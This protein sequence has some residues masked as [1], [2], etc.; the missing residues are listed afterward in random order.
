MDPF[1]SPEEAFNPWTQ[2]D[3][4]DDDDD[5]NGE[6]APNRYHMPSRQ[7]Q[8]WGHISQDYTLDNGSPSS[9]RGDITDPLSF[10]TSAA[11][12]PVRAPSSSVSH[13]STNSSLSGTMAISSGVSM[14]LYLPCE[15]NGFAGFCKGAW[16]LQIGVKKAFKPESRPAGMYNDI[17]FWRCSKCYYEGPMAGGVTK[18]TR[19]YDNHVRIHHATGI[20]YRWVFLAKSHIAMRKVP[21]GTDGTVGTFG[22]I[23]CCAERRA[24]A[25]T[26]GNLSVFMEHLLQ[27]R[28]VA[29]GMDS[30]LDR[31][32]CIVGRVA[33]LAEDF[34]INIPP[35]T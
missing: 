13:R 34:D 7:T 12:P 20:R 25:P 3:P 33:D 9:A 29:L 16:K 14:T 8:S 2:E 22:C 32:R 11:A 23:F 21:T 30:L 35:E 4:D 19:T 27:H 24:P 31:T 17:P 10:Y 1:L 18:T 15:E 6:V 26:F 5:D 28:Y